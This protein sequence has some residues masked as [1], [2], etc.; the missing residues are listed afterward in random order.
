MQEK[1]EEQLKE[2]FGPIHESMRGYFA[3]H[4]FL[5]MARDD[6]IHLLLG[7]L[8]YGMF[9]KHIEYFPNRVTNTGA[10]EQAMMGIAC[11]L[12]LEGKKVF[13]YSITTFL[14]YRAFET[15]RNYID[16]E[17]IPVRLV[18]SGRDRDYAHDGFSHWSEDV[19]KLFWSKEY[20]DKGITPFFSNI[21]TLFPKDKE[22]IPSLVSSMV[23]NN[24]PWFISLRR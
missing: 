21:F 14:L 6:D 24:D 11:G 23:E 15:I 7:D 18:G 13:V 5:A 4:F 16:H 9:D 1:T 17:K 19:N 3:Y 12:A 22:E 20:F 10:A 8:G 2:L